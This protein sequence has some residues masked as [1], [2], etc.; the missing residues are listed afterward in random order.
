VLHSLV[1]DV[2]LL[3]VEIIANRVL[4][5]GRLGAVHASSRKQGGQ[6]G[7]GYP[8]NLVPQDMVDA[9]LLI[10]YLLF[11]PLHQP[12][13]DLTKKYPCFRDGVKES[14]LGVAPYFPGQ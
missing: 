7:Q 2:A 12:F 13:G 14:S 4:P 11:Q 1:A 9:F 6:L 5:I 3:V 10:G 8:E